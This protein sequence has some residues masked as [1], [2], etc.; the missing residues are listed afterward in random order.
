MTNFNKN[1]W[2]KL[3][4]L[5]LI[6]GFRFNYALAQN[7]TTGN[8]NYKNNPVW[9]LMMDDPDVNYFEALKAYETYWKYHKKPTGEEEEMQMMAALTGEKMSKKQVRKKKEIEREQKRAAEKSASKTYS[10]KE[11]LEI[12][13]KEN[14]KYQIKRFENWMLDV[15]PFVQEDGSILSDQEKQSIWIKQQEELNNKK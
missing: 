11:Q 6:T 3:L 12:S 9:I 7:N 15:K 5:A 10:K 13:E 1:Y 2:L 4:F 14:M 8:E